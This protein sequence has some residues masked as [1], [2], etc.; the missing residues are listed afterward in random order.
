LPDN[1]PAGKARY[2][3]LICYPCNPIQEF[4]PVCFTTPEISFMV[5]DPPQT[6]GSNFDPDPDESFRKYKR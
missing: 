4:W 5:G 6:G 1:L 2:V 3:S